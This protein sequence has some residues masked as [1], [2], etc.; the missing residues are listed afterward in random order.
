MFMSAVE[1]KKQSDINAVRGT[2]RQEW[3]KNQISQ[4]IKEGETDVLISWV[5]EHKFYCE[6]VT[7]GYAVKEVGSMCRISWDSPVSN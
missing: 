7:A 5:P 4:A 3:L 1:A 6:F 2:E